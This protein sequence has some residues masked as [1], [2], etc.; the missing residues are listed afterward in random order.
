MAELTVEQERDA[1]LE[2]IQLF[3]DES[4]KC[5]ML[6]IEGHDEWT[7]WITMVLKNCGAI[8]KE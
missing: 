8:I 5:P 3:L 2:A 4:K 1:I 6:P 7:D